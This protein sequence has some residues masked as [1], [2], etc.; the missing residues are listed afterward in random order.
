MSDSADHVVAL[1]RVLRNALR[2]RVPPDCFVVPR[3][4]QLRER[5]CEYEAVQARL[6]AEEFRSSFEGAGVSM[7]DFTTALLTCAEVCRGVSVICDN[8]VRLLLYRIAL[9]QT[10]DPA[11]QAQSV[12][13]ALRYSLARIH[14]HLRREQLVLPAAQSYLDWG[15]LRTCLVVGVYICATGDMLTSVHLGGLSGIKLAQ[16]LAMPEFISALELV[17]RQDVGML[18]DQTLTFHALCWVVRWVLWSSAP[19]DARRIRACVH[20]MRTVRKLLR[21][22]QAYDEAEE[23][24]GHDHAHVCCGCAC[25]AEIA[26]PDAGY[27][28]AEPELLVELYSAIITAKAVLAICNCTGHSSVGWVRLR[29]NLIAGQGRQEQLRSCGCANECINL[30]GY[31]DAGIKLWLCSACQS[32][33][34]C[35]EQCRRED[36][37]RHR[38]RCRR[39]AAGRL[40]AQ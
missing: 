31:S 20:L 28:V 18:A 35:S 32:V 11:L 14:R 24:T 15:V 22:M 25:L 29:A 13:G 10:S 5:V 17:V 1:H 21:L 27:L 33:V 7:N 19:T 12:R 23:W 9:L 36:L 37:A 4:R 38:R 34:Y 2:R 8:L 26:A 39:L 30:D 40:A 6:T 3:R 16:L